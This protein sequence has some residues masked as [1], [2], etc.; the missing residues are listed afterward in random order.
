MITESEIAEL[1]LKILPPGGEQ[2]TELLGRFRER[3]T[4]TS[5]TLENVPL[6]ILARH[7]MIAR[8]P[9]GGD[10]EKLSQASAIVEA[11]SRFFQGNDTLYLYINLPDLPIPSFVDALISE[12]ALHVE[13]KDT[14]RQA[15]DDALTRGDRREFARLAEEFRMLQTQLQE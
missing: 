1:R 2:V 12:I 4:L 7:G 5:V 15:I 11:L 13:R 6:V 10:L 3:V 8:L 14:L 9:K